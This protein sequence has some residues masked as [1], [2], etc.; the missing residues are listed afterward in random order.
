MY[1]LKLE[2]KEHEDRVLDEVLSGILNSRFSDLRFCLYF[3]S[4]IGAR[5]PGS[6]KF[7]FGLP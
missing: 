4:K 1:S 2:A 3:K 7:D 6:I 5:N